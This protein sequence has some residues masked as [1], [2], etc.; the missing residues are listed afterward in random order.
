MGERKW[1]V[2]ESNLHFYV[3]N[4]RGYIIT[5]FCNNAAVAEQIVREHNAHDDLV[6][7]CEMALPLL[8]CMMT[9]DGYDGPIAAAVRRCELAIALI[10]EVPT[11]VNPKPK[12]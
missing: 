1:S 5:R 8:S 9:V 6:K 12:T 3:I 11:Q 10:R 4:E 7:A 2:R